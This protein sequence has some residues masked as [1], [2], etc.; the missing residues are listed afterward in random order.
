VCSSS[1]TNW[2]CASPLRAILGKDCDVVTASSGDDALKLVEKESID[3][4][5]LDLRMPGSGASPCSSG[6]KKIDPEIEA[7]IITGYGS[8]DTAIAGAPA[9]RVRLH[10]E[11]V[12]LRSGRRRP[13]RPRAAARD[14]AAALGAGAD[15]RDPVARVPHAAQRDHG[16]LDDA[17][18]TRASR[19]S[20]EQRS[21]STAIQSNSTALLAYVETLFY[22]VELD[23]GMVAIQCAR[24]ASP[25]CSRAWPTTCAASPR[26]RVSASAIEDRAARALD[27]RREADA[28]V[29]ALADNAVR[30]TLSGEVV[31]PRR[32][33]PTAASSSTSRT[34]VP[35]WR[36]SSWPRR[37]T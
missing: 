4:V 36:P 20:D 9:T 19:L 10:L 29:R 17:A 3:L 33:G 31:L 5:T 37:A 1:T 18:A 28:L 6:I 16:L 32:A 7:L 34:R 24:F 21:R 15:P 23:R 26:R 25:R 14:E 22:M 11:A 2:G 27:R 8:L 13:G 12:R 30:Y 35:A